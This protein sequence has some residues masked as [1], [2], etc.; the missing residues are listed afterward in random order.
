MKTFK[1]FCL[2]T[3]SFPLQIIESI[4]QNCQLIIDNILE[5]LL[6]NPLERLNDK[7]LLK[8]MDIEGKN[9]N[10]KEDE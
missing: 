4:V 7:I 10:K 1:L 5:I 9:K 6:L 8:I 2:Y 3:I